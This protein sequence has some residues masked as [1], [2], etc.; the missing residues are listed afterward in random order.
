[1]ISYILIIN[2]CL[3]FWI[4]TFIIKYPCWMYTINDGYQFDRKITDVYCYKRIV[5]NR[6]HTIV[7]IL[8]YDTGKL[9][10]YDQ[11]SSFGKLWL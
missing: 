2:I 3:A 9:Y 5:N 10:P 1:M 11:R 8:G 6:F 4:W 7:H